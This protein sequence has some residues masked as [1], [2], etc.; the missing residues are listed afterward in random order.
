VSG[1]APTVAAAHA[2]P[3]GT[4]ARV[5]RIFSTL[6][7]LL[8]A[9]AL[10]AVIAAGASGVRVRVE[11]T[12]SMAPVLHPGD[13]VLVRSTPIDRVRIGDV[14][15]VRQTSGQVIVHRVER[16]DGA[17][18]FLRVHTRGDANPTG[19]DWQIP[20]GG[21]VALVKGSVPHV[22]T[23][24]TAIKGPAAAIA[25]IVAALLLAFSALRAVWKRG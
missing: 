21:S 4:V 20:R 5:G 6:L 17:Q 13:L 24:V 9:M 3:A 19:E 18:G 2:R 12:G 8:A 1:A 23:V 11:R 22:G 14:I 16:I 15:G 7:L 10:A 25:M